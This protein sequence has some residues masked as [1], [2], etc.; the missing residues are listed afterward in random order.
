[1]AA[2]VQ[3]SGPQSKT[4][5]RDGALVGGSGAWEEEQGDD[6]DVIYTHIKLS[7]NKLMYEILSPNFNCCKLELYS[8]GFSKS[9]FFPIK[10]T[11]QSF[12]LIRFLMKIM[13]VQKEGF[14]GW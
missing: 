14:R 2:L 8:L 13:F 6:Q 5:E 12:Q 9:R 4:R 3:S 10:K 11:I 7:K 1:M